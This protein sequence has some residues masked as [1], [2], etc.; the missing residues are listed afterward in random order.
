MF[1]VKVK[2]SS[3]LGV[4][5]LVVLV[6]VTFCAG[7]DGAALAT[8]S[9]N[10]TRAVAAAMILKITAIFFIGLFSPLLMG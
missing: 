10:I 8:D 9:I 2:I 5:L 7:A 6:N 3:T 4:G 1:T